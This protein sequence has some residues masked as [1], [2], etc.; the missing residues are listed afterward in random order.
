LRNHNQ[1]E[2]KK[3]SIQSFATRHAHFVSPAMV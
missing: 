1:N 2:Q 3:R